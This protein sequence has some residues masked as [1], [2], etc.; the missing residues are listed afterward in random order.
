ML[1]LGI[2]TCAS[3]EVVST[4]DAGFANTGKSS[5]SSKKRSWKLMPK[6]LSKAFSS[7]FSERAHVDNA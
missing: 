4:I 1:V 7:R 3:M 2:P 6:D 5:W